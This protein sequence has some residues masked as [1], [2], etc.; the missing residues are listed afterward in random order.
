[1]QASIVRCLM[2]DP[3]DRQIFETDVFRMVEALICSK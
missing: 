3:D 1:M 2:A